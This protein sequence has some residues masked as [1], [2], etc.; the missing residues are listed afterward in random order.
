MKRLSIILLSMF[1]LF[2]LVACG[3]ATTEK[4]TTGNNNNQQTT[5][6]KNNNN[7]STTSDNQQ[8]VTTTQSGGSGTT[9]KVTFNFN[10]RGSTNVVV[11]VVSGETVDRPT[12]PTRDGYTFGGWFKDNKGNEEFDFSTPINK[13]TTIY[14]YWLADQAQVVFK[15]NDNV[16][17]D[18]TVLVNIGTAVSQPLNP[19]RDGFNFGGWYTD[20]ECT[21]E[22]DFTQA[23]TQRINL[24][25][26]WTKTNVVVTYDFNYQDAPEPRTIV[27][28]MSSTINRPSDP[29]RDTYEFVGWYKDRLGTQEYDF[30]TVL[31]DDITLYAKWSRNVFYVTFNPNYQGG[32]EVVVRVNKGNAVSK[33][34]DITTYTGH[35]FSKWVLDLT[36]NT[37]YDFTSL[38]NDDITLYA[39]YTLKTY[40]VSFDLN[41]AGA[42]GNVPNQTVEYG[43]FATVP[44]TD[45]SCEGCTFQGWYTTQSGTDAFTFTL[46]PIT[47]DTTIYAK[48]QEGQQTKTTVVAKFFYNINELG[49]YLT[50]Q[51]IRVGR[52]LARPQAPVLENYYFENWYTDEACTTIFDFGQRLYDDVNL[53]AKWLTKYTF[54]A[55]NVDLTGKKG[56][57]SSSNTFE[58]GMLK[59]QDIGFTYV[60]GETEFPQYYQDNNSDFLDPTVSNDWYLSDLYYTNAYFEFK[61]NLSEATD[62]AVIYLRC[63]SDYYDITLDSDDLLLIINGE[64]DEHGQYIPGT[65][66]VTHETMYITHTMPSPIGDD[67]KRQFEDYF[68]KDKVSL[69]AGEN[70]IRFQ[71]NNTRD[72]GGTYNAEAPMVDCMYIYSEVEITWNPI[73]TFLD[74]AKALR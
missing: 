9:Y 50:D 37:E 5:T 44:E 33:P 28:N 11:Q 32:E 61:I 66:I 23:V 7:S 65:G 63:S 45:P 62:C 12:D 48:W 36:T 34:E 54:E 14:A 56:Q 69:N 4:T 16:R 3:N 58:H 47:S 25:A 57:G 8:V 59:T 30:D 38:V 55:E 46:T 1:I 24:Y 18:E 21:I 29:I 27:A 6:N 52:I 71:V 70:I 41:R 31:E 22:Y 35:N 42:T 20:V 72:H 60:P 40:T 53:Y 43:S 15:F 13:N 19:L 68:L 73:Q 17:E 39:T 2:G 67:H 26:K 49:Q 64:Y 10:Y 51:E 74:R